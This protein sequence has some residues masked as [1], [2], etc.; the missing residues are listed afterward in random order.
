MPY[1][2]HSILYNPNSSTSNAIWGNGGAG[3]FGTTNTTIGQA[4]RAATAYAGNSAPIRITPASYVIY[5]F[6]SAK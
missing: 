5:N 1:H 4:G 6:I 2:N 3:N